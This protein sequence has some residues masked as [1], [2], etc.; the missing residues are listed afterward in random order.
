MLDA[1]AEAQ[2]VLSEE[3]LRSIA[4]INLTCNKLKINAKDEAEDNNMYSAIDGVT[5]K[6]K[7]Q[8]TKFKDKQRRHL[9]GDKQSIK[10]EVLDAID[11][12]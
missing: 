8:I 12:E 9:A 5:E 2:V 4:E 11:T 7:T 6:I 10:D 3:K 1:P